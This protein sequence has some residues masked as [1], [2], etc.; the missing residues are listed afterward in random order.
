MR[1]RC[2][3]RLLGLAGAVVLT[4]GLAACGGDDGSG[5]EIPRA[6][7][8][9]MLAQISQIE[10]ATAS[11]ECDRDAA[12]TSTTELR[13]QV[14]ALEGQVDAETYDALS[15]MVS[16][17]DE[18]L[19]VE[20]VDTGTSDTED[21][22]ETTETTAPPATTETTESTAPP[23]T[24]EPPPE[25]EEDEGGGP[26]V[27]PPGQGGAPPGQAPEGTPGGGTPSGGIEEEGR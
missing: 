3:T 2:G 18:Q 13:S 9:E 10:Q 20:C 1:G 8:E 14:D 11:E 17:L 16:R 4:L 12:Q 23:T 6:A 22:T 7:G 21:T 26:P 25:E 27:Q 19:E 15:Q 24:E 5:G